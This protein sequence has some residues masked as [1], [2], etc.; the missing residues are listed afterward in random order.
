M[1]TEDWQEAQRLRDRLQSRDDK[2][3]DIVRDGEQIQFADWVEFSS[4]IIPSRRSER[5]RPTQR[6]SVRVGASNRRS[7]SDRSMT[8]PQMNSSTTFDGG[9]RLGFTGAQRPSPY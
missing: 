7:A 3:L 5:K 2:I 9:F 6:T 8:S 1:N 4:R